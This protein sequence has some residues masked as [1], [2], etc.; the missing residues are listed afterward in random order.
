MI[1]LD[2]VAGVFGSDALDSWERSGRTMG[3]IAQVSADELARMMEGGG[4]HVLDVRGSAEWEA[5]H[6]PGVP[7]IPGG[8]L[9]DL[10]SGI[11]DHMTV[12]MQCQGSR[13]SNKRAD[14]L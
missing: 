1:G 7:N 2:R 9:T 13:G 10:L 14:V 8:Y 12:V 3:T 5:G 6:L 4:V 11:T